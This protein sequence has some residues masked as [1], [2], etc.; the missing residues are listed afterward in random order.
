MVNIALRPRRIFEQES[1]T[2]YR[3]VKF[4]KWR[5]PDVVSSRSFR[6]FLKFLGDRSDHMKTAHRPTFLVM[7]VEM[8]WKP[9][10]SKHKT[11]KCK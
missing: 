7:F 6:S 5:E 1:A 3:R 8:I 10:L 4:E 2:D 9:T 11:A